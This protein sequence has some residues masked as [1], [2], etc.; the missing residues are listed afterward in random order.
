MIGGK[1]V[2]IKVSSD[3]EEW[4]SYYFDAQL[5]VISERSTHS[6]KLLLQ[7]LRHE[8]MHASLAISGVS[9]STDFQEEAVCRCM[10]EIFFP[11]YERL[12]TKLDK[13]HEQ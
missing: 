10:D 6:R 13:T 11:A 7:T 8:M 2:K 4:G 5:I 12:I 9:F 1:R 3:I